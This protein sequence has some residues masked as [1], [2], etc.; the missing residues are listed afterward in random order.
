MIAPKAPHA[1][2]SECSLCSAPFVPSYSPS[3]P[4]IA[5]V[6]EAPGYHEAKAA[7]PFVGASGKLL[8]AVLEHIDIPTERCFKTNAV[9]CRPDHNDL[10]KHADAIRCCAPRLYAEL[11]ALQVE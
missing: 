4:I 10:S 3:E 2:C 8:D 5:L 1:L 6:G 9:L 11:A 7:T